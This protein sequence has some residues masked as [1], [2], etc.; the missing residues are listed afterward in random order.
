MDS[1]KYMIA[2]GLI[3]TS[4]NDHYGTGF[5]DFFSSCISQFR[6]KRTSNPRILCSGWRQKK[7]Q[8]KPS[9]WPEDIE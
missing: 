7:V 9:F 4:K 5:L 8:E 2:C 3:K 6:L 1:E